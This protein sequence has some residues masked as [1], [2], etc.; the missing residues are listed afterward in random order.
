MS[1]LLF[2]FFYCSFDFLIIILICFQ[3]N[4]LMDN[5]AVLEEADEPSMG[6]GRLGKVPGYSWFERSDSLI[7]LFAVILSFLTGRAYSL[8]Y[9]CDDEREL[10]AVL[11]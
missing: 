4:Q 3:G 2:V 7:I 9:N 8:G 6:A 10:E 11:R 5:N 1:I